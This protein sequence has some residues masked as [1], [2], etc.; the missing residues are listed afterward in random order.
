MVVLVMQWVNFLFCNKDNDAK[1]EWEAGGSDE[2]RIMD[3]RC[4]VGRE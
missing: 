2:D 3:K 1:R 4:K